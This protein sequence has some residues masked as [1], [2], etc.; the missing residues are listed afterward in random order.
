M[1]ICWEDRFRKPVAKCLIKSQL[2][3]ST[4]QYTVETT[5]ETQTAIGMLDA[6]TTTT[7]E[8]KKLHLKEKTG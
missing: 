1:A 4:F 8:K 7:Q 3:I 6:A 2:P 5:L